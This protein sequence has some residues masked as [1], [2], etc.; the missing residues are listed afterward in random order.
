MV[1]LPIELRAHMYPRAV[2]FSIIY[3]PTYFEYS[4]F[5]VELCN[6]YGSLERDTILTPSLA[7]AHL[8]VDFVDATWGKDG[9]IPPLT[10]ITI[11]VRFRVLAAET[12]LTAGVPPRFGDFSPPCTFALLRFGN[13]AGKMAIRNCTNDSAE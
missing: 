7:A 3:S 4:E 9:D 10:E 12:D 2:N 6:G 5:S 13:E 8:G 11:S 1:V